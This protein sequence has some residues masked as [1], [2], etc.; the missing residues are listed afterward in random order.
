MLAR[1]AWAALIGVVAVNVEASVLARDTLLGAYRVFWDAGH[2]V[3]VTEPREADFPKAIVVTNF[4]PNEQPSLVCSDHKGIERPTVEAPTALPHAAMRHDDVLPLKFGFVDRE[5]RPLVIRVVTPVNAPTDVS[6]WQVASVFDH[7]LAGVAIFAAGE[8]ADAERSDR[9][10]GALKD[11]RIALLALPGI[12]GGSP[13]FVSGVPQKPRKH[14]DCDG[15]HGLDSWSRQQSI[16]KPVQKERTAIISGLVAGLI[17][18]LVMY[19]IHRARMNAPSEAS[20][21]SKPHRC[22]E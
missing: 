8:A 15:S 6:G 13:Q 21:E 9:D 2:I 19:L 20:S 11:A 3:S 10:V 4:T 16:H 18:G 14:S 5:K 7:D 12:A 22:R 17:F 1:A